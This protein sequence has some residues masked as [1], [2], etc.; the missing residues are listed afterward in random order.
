MPGYKMMVIFL[1]FLSFFAILPID[2][3]AEDTFSGMTKIKLP[4]GVT[5]VIKE[6]NRA[7]VVAV[8][9]WVKAGSAYEKDR[10][11]GITH[12][13]EHM[14]FKG[15]GKMGPGQLARQIEA[16]G[17]SINAYTSLD[18]TVYHCEAPR[19]FLKEAVDA[20]SDAVLNSTFDP[21]ELEREKKVVLEEMKMRNDMPSAAL[22]Q[23]LMKTSY[24]KSPYR[25]PVIGLADTVKSFTRQDILNYMARRYTPGNINIIIVGDIKAQDAALCVT[26]AFKRLN[27]SRAAADIKTPEPLQTSNRLASET[28]DTQQGRLAI[29]FSGAPDFNDPDAPVLD[30]MAA[31]LGNGDS[32]RLNRR[33]K[34]ELQLVYNIGSYAFTPSGPGLFEVVAT[35]APGKTRN[36]IK[37]ILRELYFLRA[38]PVSKEELGKAKTQVETDFVYNQETMDGEAEKLGM[39][40]IM[41]Q[42]PD[43]EALYLKRVRSVTS[44]DIQRLAGRIFRTDNINIAVIMPKGKAQDIS[45]AELTEIVKRAKIKTPTA[46]SKKK[47]ST[48]IKMKLSNGVTVLARRVSDVPTM[49]IQAVFPGGV[50]YESEASNGLFNFLAK[51]W[52]KGTDLHSSQE[53]AAII[54]GMGGNIDGF[55]GQNSFGLGGRFLSNHLEDGLSLF[56]EILLRPAFP[57]EEVER[58]KPLIIADLKRQED[59][60]SSVAIREFRRELFRPHPY[61]MNPIGAEAPVREMATGKLASA[62]KEFARPDQ[63]I[64]SVVGDINPDEVIK[65][66]ETYLGGWKG[67]GPA[68]TPKLPAPERLD[69]PRVFNLQKDRQQT[70]LVL[71][72]AG[73][74]F[75]AKDRY[76]LEVLNAVLAGQG[77]RLFTELRDKESLAYS[78][79]SFVGLGVDYGSFGLYIASAPEKKGR[80]VEGLWHE[81]GRVRADLVSDDELERAKTWLIGNYEISLQTN[82]SQAMDLAL[83]ELYG[84]GPNFASE[85]YA[86]EIKNVTAKDVFKAA[87]CFLNPKAYV[88]VEVGP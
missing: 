78:V 50:R 75:T 39:F 79:T 13:I 12:L 36:A 25:R 7:Q 74:T 40:T 35:L 87:K 72:F 16:M 27:P 1:A 84:L 26:D 63:A 73:V 76:A 62:Y 80:A 34:E 31:L 32:A 19:E 2:A 18:Y 6:S 21:L 45:E 28:M 81:I 29:A 11:A 85:R 3:W 23:L 68:V 24:E 14:I 59:S 65:K 48:F 22:S 61:S 44:Q 82:G 10:E 33:I 9:I 42:D 67:T 55:S 71:G 86:A 64:I 15:T 70:H 47:P 49:S 41:A 54:D 66:L 46:R 83:N 5:A 56:S 60:L 53:L 37:A 51:A 17:G 57:P 38:D 58:L 69:A 43:A 4:N 30:V 20:L 88:L 8:Q 77:G 52:V